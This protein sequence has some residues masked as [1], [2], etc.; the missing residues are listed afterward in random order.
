M[1]LGLIL[2][3]CEPETVFNALRLAAY[4]LAQGDAVRIFLVGK[5]VDIEQIDAL[6]L[7]EVAPRVSADP[8]SSLRA[9][10]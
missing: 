10:Q 5:G 9:P 6:R 2:S 3:Q 8:V 4:S 1:K 7:T